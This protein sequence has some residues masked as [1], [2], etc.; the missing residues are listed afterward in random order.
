MRK[1]PIILLVAGSLFLMSGIAMAASSTT[2]TVTYA[3]SAINEISVSGNPAALTVSTATAGSA[4][5]SVSDATTTYAITTNETGKKITGAINSNMP[6]GV[7]LTVSLAAPTGGTSAGATSLSTS[8]SN[9][10]TGIT[11]LNE[12]GKT[13]T[14]SLSATS[15]AGVVSSASKTVTLTVV[16]GP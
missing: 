11:T 2:Q 1:I 10:V 4:P 5:N 8:A 15:A 7:T 14:Y 16:D 3:V 13:I 9:L 6:A 12:S